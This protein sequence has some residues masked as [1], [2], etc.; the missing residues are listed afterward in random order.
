MIDNIRK[1]LF[2]TFLPTLMIL[3][4][5]ADREDIPPAGSEGEGKI[6]LNL[7]CLTR[8]DDSSDIEVMESLRIIL[9]DNIGKVKANDFID[10]NSLPDSHGDEPELKSFQY[11]WE[12]KAPYGRYHLYVIANEKSITDYD[13]QGYA[14]SYQDKS[15]SQLLESYEAGRSG[16]SALLKGIYFKPDFTKPIVL[17][18]DYAIDFNSSTSRFNAYLVNVATKFDLNFSNYR[19]EPVTFSSITLEQVADRNFLIADID[20]DHKNVKGKY[21]IDWMKGVVEDTNRY[22]ELDNTDQSNDKINELWGWLTEYGM[23]QGTVHSPIKLVDTEDT[24]TV[25]VSTPQTGTLPIPGKLYK[26]PYYF[27]ESKYIKE[28]KPSQSYSLTFEVLQSDGTLKTFNRDLGK[29]KTLFRNTYAVIDVEIS[30][31]VESIYVEVYPWMDKDRF[32]GTVSPE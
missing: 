25:P 4:S 8:G 7:S 10:L 18:C 9:L 31:G 20:D 12:F 2:F 29:I 16:M 32:Y 23:P 28:G 1:F 3:T 19:N 30:R 17:S 21:W 13:V 15:F 24:W 14:E 6:S 11:D 5:C 27:P 22:P 26:G